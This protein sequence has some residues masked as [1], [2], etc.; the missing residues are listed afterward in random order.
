MKRLLLS[1][2]TLG[3]I[4]INAQSIERS[5]IGSTGSTVDNGG[6][7]VSSTV[8][9]AVVTTHSVGSFMITQGYQQTEGA[10]SSVEQEQVKVSYR[11]FP[12]PTKD[13]SKLEFN[14]EG[15]NI[16]VTISVYGVDGKLVYS[17]LINESCSEVVDLDLTK[18][19]SGV[20]FVKIY[21]LNSEVLETIKLIKHYSLHF[22]SFKRK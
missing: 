5:V 19:K 20:Y 13:I 17:M 7:S 14:A 21:N 12:N 1:F 11:L 3:A 9:E 22:D 6:V 8:G 2:M 18:E 4:V 16:N 15:N 10:F